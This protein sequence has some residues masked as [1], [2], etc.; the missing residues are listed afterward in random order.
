VTVDEEV[1]GVE[2]PVRPMGLGFFLDVH[3]DAVVPAPL[4]QPEERPA[5]GREEHQRQA[6]SLRPDEPVD[7]SDVAPLDLDDF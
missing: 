4:I 2:I 7:G 1:V 3:G 5:L 6:A